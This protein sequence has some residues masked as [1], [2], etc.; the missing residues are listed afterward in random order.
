M[1]NGKKLNNEKSRQSRTT[2]LGILRKNIVLRAVLVIF[3]VVLTIVLLFALTVAWYTNVV[4]SGGLTFTAQQWN[5]DGTVNLY[6]TEQEAFPGAEGIISMQLINEGQQTLAAS[7]TVS[8][9]N[10]MTDMH[11]RMFFYVDTSIVRNGELM[12]RVWVSATK[13][14]TYTVFPNSQLNLT[15]TTQNAPALK[16]MWV[17]DV[18]GYYVLG[19]ET[20]GGGVSVNEYIR[21]VEYEYDPVYTTFDAEGF[22]VRINNETTVGDFLKQVTSAD[23]YTG[24]L[25]ETA[26]RNAEGYYRVDVDGSGYGVW[27]YL[28]RYSEIQEHMETD[29][30]LGSEQ[31]ITG[32]VNISVTGQNSIAE[33]TEITTADALVN[34]L[35]QPYAGVVQLA[36]DITLT[37]PLALTDTSY[38]MLDLGG[39]TITSTASEIITAESGDTIVLYNGELV[40]SGAAGSVGIYSSGANVTLNNVNISNVEEGLKIFDH[41]NAVGADS[42]IHLID[43]TITGAQDGLWIYGNGDASERSTAIVIEN[44]DIIGEG[45]AGIICNGSLSNRGTDIQ[46]TGGSVSGYY[47]GIYHPGKDSILTVTETKVTG[48]T[49]VVAKGGIVYL[50]NCEIN[51]S[52][53]AEEVQAPALNPGG[54]SDTGDGVYLETAYEWQTIVYISGANTKINSANGLAVRQYEAGASQ[55][56]IIISGGAFSSDVTEYLI[57]GAI[58]T[59]EDGDGIY[60][61][62]LNQDQTGE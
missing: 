13:S 12:D 22:P 25:D 40:G 18:L 33:A 59:D 28:C 14:Y 29:T 31:I 16:W 26:Q 15:E 54:W 52:A 6:N 5:F 51:G 56:S 49:G 48:M 46:I 19:T 8:K 39:H 57:D 38:A 34:A 45:Y 20:S 62:A 2:L 10:L 44:C 7:V 60:T 61:I 42:R 41:K 58:C 27:L 1:K 23:G 55:G 36:N 4:Q 47:A 53:T 9:A 35:N 21:P 32:Q 37:E 3:T 17:Y 50:V 43:C 11:K 24:V 30:R